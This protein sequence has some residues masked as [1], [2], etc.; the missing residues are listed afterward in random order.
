MNRLRELIINTITAVNNRDDWEH[1]DALTD[2]LIKEV[3]E[4]DRMFAELHDDVDVESCDAHKNMTP[5]E[6]EIYIKV[7]N[8]FT[9]FMLFMDGRVNTSNLIAIEQLSERVGAVLDDLEHPD[10]N[11]PNIILEA[12]EEKNDE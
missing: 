1:L 7:D 4:M 10:H 11:I 6:E 8:L 3:N 12:F 9:R 5:E 2:L